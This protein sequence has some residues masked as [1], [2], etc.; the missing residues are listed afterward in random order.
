MD[1]ANRVGAHMVFMAHAKRMY[2]GDTRWL[3]DRHES[4]KTKTLLNRVDKFALMMAD[5]DRSWKQSRLVSRGPDARRERRAPGHPRSSL[6]YAWRAMLPHHALALER[7][8]RPS[9]IWKLN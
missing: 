5:G 9:P 1:L 3:A 4:L 2:N 6:M 8:H 7:F